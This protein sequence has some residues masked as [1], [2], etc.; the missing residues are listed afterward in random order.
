M[1]NLIDF[2]EENTNTQ[3]VT[4]KPDLDS[5]DITINE[6]LIQDPN[7]VYTEDINYDSIYDSVSDNFDSIIK[8]NKEVYDTICPEK[9]NYTKK[10]INSGMSKK[11]AMMFSLYSMMAL[12][13]CVSAF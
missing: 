10:L 2:K 9:N 1:D 6:E 8:D 11:K 4:Y 13:Y 3:K 12:L 5:L 7:N